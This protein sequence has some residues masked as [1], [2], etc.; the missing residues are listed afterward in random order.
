MGM[1]VQR[2][3]PATLPRERPGTY[4]I[5]GWVGPRV[6]L[7]GCG[8][9]CP[10]QDSIPGRPAC[11]ESLYRLSYPGQ[12]SVARQCW[13]QFIIW[14]VSGLI[15]LTFHAVGQFLKNSLTLGLVK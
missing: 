10:H 4:C 14:L 11:I 2:H 3:F 9:S 7:D 1:G 12:D 8:K 5:G 6:G 15:P 13:M